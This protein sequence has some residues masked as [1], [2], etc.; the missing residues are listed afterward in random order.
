MGFRPAPSG[1]VADG[2]YTVKDKFV[3]VYVLRSNTSLICFDAG[4]TPKGITKGFRELGLNPDDVKAVFLTHSDRDHVNALPVFKN[5]MVYLP[6][7]E[8]PLVTGAAKRHLMFIARTNKLPVDKYTLIKDGEVVK[9]GETVIKAYLTPGH[10]LGSTSYL[11]DGKYLAV[12]DLAITKKGRLI[13]MPKPPSEDPKMIKESLKII[14][15]IKGVEYV[16]T[17]HGGVLKRKGE[18]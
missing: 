11:A 2:L 5:A 15:G 6:E 3:A 1:Q 8:E 16:L 17:G 18:P 7:K 4:N 14:E 13:G 12:G 10:S 9:L